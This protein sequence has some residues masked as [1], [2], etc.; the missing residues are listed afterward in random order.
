[1]AKNMALLICK[2]IVKEFSGFV[3]LNNV[4]IEVNEGEI[5]GL[6]GPNGAGKT[7][8]FNCIRGILSMERG[9]IM[10]NGLDITSKSPHQIALKGL[11]TSFQ[12]VRL[13]NEMSVL[14]N[15]I[16]AIQQ[17]Q[18]VNFFKSIFRLPSERKKEKEAMERALEMLRFFELIHL[19]DEKAKNLSYGQKKLLS[20]A[21]AFAPKP[22]LILLDEPAAYVNPTL[23]EKI[24]HYIKELSKE[25][26]TIVIIEHNMRVIMDLCDRIYAFN[27]GRVI[28]EG[29]PEEIKNNLQVIAA[30]FGEEE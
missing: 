7:T 9:H 21:M 4:S 10:F 19:K 1:M 13:F 20:L 30:Y 16:M 24:K 27:E 18:G 25:G 23:I 29:S 6:I 17:Q 5:V 11:R 2:N 26:V 22:K 3:A 14:D 28:A 12:I 15:V 8:L